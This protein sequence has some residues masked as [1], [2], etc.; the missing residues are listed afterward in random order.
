M[1]GPDL[2]IDSTRIPEFQF[3]SK[4]DTTCKLGTK[5]DSRLTF[6]HRPSLKLAQSLLAKHH[7]INLEPSTLPS[8]FHQEENIRL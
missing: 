6:Q 4:P 3:G 2:K 5:P 8:N 1:F 7:R